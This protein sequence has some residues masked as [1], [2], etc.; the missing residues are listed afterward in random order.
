MKIFVVDDELL[1][2]DMAKQAIKEALPNEE[3]VCFDKSSKLLEY[4]KDV[5][6]DVVF[7]DVEMPGINGITLAKEI[8]SIAPFVNI[9]FITGYSEYSFDAFKLFAS[10]YILKPVSCE[11]ILNVMHNLRYKIESEKSIVIKTF[12]NFSVFNN[13]KPVNFRLAKSKE[14]LAYLV[15]REG[16]SLSRKEVTAVLFE[17]DNYSRII[18]SDLARAAKWLE[19]DLINAG[20]NNL[21]I[22]DNAKY[23]VNCDVFSCDLY[24]YLKGEKSVKYAGE[25]MEQYSWGEYRKG[26]LE[27]IKR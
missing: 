6:P 17:D 15:D 25:Y 13:G 5:H 11:D 4:C 18:Q 19:D 21:F 22:R 10:G 12:G 27:N 8:K 24:D 2:L 20:I 1:M 7:M 26:Y 16:S 3:P 9:I 23:S 14:L